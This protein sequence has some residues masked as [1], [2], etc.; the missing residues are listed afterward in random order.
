MCWNDVQSSFS[1]E[2]ALHDQLDSPHL[3]VQDSR[4]SPSDVSG[5]VA[6]NHEPG[7]YIEIDNFSIVTAASS[8]VNRVLMGARCR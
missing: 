2:M 7:G 5:S 3:S 8:E 1:S 4:M 6:D